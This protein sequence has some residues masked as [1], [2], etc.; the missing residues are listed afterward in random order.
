MRKVYSVLIGIFFTLAFT[1]CKQFNADIDEY[2]SYWSAEAFIRS[3]S[4][5]A[6][7]QTDVTGVASV[8]SE[9]DVTVTLKVQNPKSFRFALPSASET[10]NIVHFEQLTEAKPVAGT[11]YELKQLEGDTLQL[12][13]KTGFLK[14]HE[15]GEKDLSSVITLIAQ[16]GRVF[17]QTYTFRI[18]A[19]TPPPKPIFTVAKTVGTPAYY[20]LCIT[21]PNM[22]KRVSGGLLHKDI[23][24]IEVNG[25]PYT[26]SVN[27]AHNA[28]TKPESDLFIT[29]SD[30]EKLTEP[31]AE[32]VPAGGWV[33][34]YKTDVEV[35]DGAAKKEYTIRLSDE[36]GLV[37]GILNASTK[38]N[39]PTAEG[40]TVTKGE[41]VSGSGS[42]SDHKII[43]SDSAGAELAI[44]SAT[45]G[46][47]VHCTLT[48]IDSAAFVQYDGN[49]ITVPLPLNGA[50]EKKY[51]LE[52]Y[53]DGE[54]FAATPVKTIYYRVVQGHTVTFDAN[55]GA[56]PDGAA[57][58]SKTAL[59]DTTISPP[60]PLPVKQGH[61]VTG[62]Y[63]DKDCSSGQEWNFDMDTV[64]G[65]I[66]LYA[67]WTAGVS[68]YTVEHYQEKLDDNYPASPIDTDDLSGMTG[69]QLSIGDGITLKN[70]P[71]FEYDYM[72]PDPA[73][74]A[75]NGSTVVKVYYKRKQ[76]TV[77]FKPNGG[78]IDGNT[79]DVTRRGKYGATFTAPASPVKTG[80]TFS[81]WQPTPPAPSLPSTFPAEDATYTAQWTANTYTVRFSVYGGP[82]GT[83]EA[84]PEG[85]TEKTTRTTDTISVEH[86]KKVTFTAQ[87]DEGYEVDSWT[88]ATADTPN[89]TAK[90]LNVTTDNINV[91]VKF[92]KKVYEVTFS[93]AAGE[94]SLKGE[95]GGHI[96]TATGNTPVT[97]TVPSGG[98]V[99]FTAT[100]KYG[101]KVEGWTASAGT[102]SGG[103]TGTTAT[104][105]VTDNATV[106]VKFKKITTVNGGD[107]AWKL[108]KKV[109]EIADDNAIITINGTIQATNDADNSGEITFGM[110][111]NKL[112]IEGGSSAVL[113]ANGKSR[114]FKV[115]GGK[116]LTLK[117]LTLQNGKVLQAWPPGSV[118]G[119]GILVNGS[120]VRMTNCTIKNCEAEGT[121]IGGAICI[122][123]TG[124][125]LHIAGG[126]ISG[127]TA[128]KGGGIYISGGKLYINTDDSGDPNS[129]STQTNITNNYTKS[130]RYAAE[131][132]GGAICSELNSELKLHNIKISQCGS[133]E[134]VASGVAQAKGGG[135]YIDG[136]TAVLTSVEISD[137][138][139]IKTP[140]DANYSGA[141][142]G[143]IYSNNANVT[144]GKSG[145]SAY[146]CHIH[147]NTIGGNG[148]S[149]T[150]EGGGIYSYKGTLK[151]YGGKIEFNKVEGHLA[152]GG[153]IAQDDTNLF[154]D[155]TVITDNTA[156]YRGGGVDG[157]NIRSF[158]ME[159]SATVTPSTQTNTSTVKYNDVYLPR[160]LYRITIEGELTPEGGTAARITPED[161]ATTPPVLAGAITTGT[162]E[163]YKKF[164]VTPPND[165]E[166]W[167]I[168]GNGCLKKQ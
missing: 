114:I 54:G 24:R 131:A 135:L 125:E 154:L 127:N 122:E 163:N 69:K 158:T 70:Y 30:V 93:V 18:K 128:N 63:R 138:T 152:K 66:R 16:D 73:T 61:G 168:D 38:P 90:L 44:S 89:T 100:P 21:V 25:T 92:K 82:H 161:Y 147:H 13:Y 43:G 143:A 109:V 7:T 117:N 159:G 45:G 48:D 58:V 76:I 1:T 20:V 108:L 60:D 41:E 155:G 101:W 5:E 39:K 151:I 99:D 50:G 166:L 26:F 4:I 35:K 110:L 22:D 112:T 88:G 156:S 57:T 29:A 59:H 148:M 116:T 9:K 115:E 37:S 46:T 64:T 94:G 86:G 6:V 95:G 15:W 165:S 28:F 8:A 104:L 141:T 139:F 14:K 2:L 81:N 160:P 119:G 51:K 65:D 118:R 36:K 97:L 80:Y 137:C 136:G 85:G 52:Y 103:G 98:N 130:D 79:G 3:A 157:L 96:D 11:D 149:G 40:V 123:G 71:G 167:E 10:R 132:N 32:E 121:C 74:I 56:Y 134:P 33:L 53:T 55:E 72:D 145:T 124:A 146:S 47:T 34:H 111:A 49:P 140:S 105:K 78:K 107:G 67:K 12:I 75:A 31:G 133:K 42:E 153:G 102:L 84:N 144:L 23:T 106:K 27:E 129:S 68:S 162:P 77:T 164:I 17:K 62:W 142:G 120:T 87:P 126:E 150:F 113:D 91:A 83:L 19:N